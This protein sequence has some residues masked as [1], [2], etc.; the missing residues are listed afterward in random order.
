VLDKEKLDGIIH[1]HFE[2]DSAEVLH[3]WLLAAE[4]QGQDA[5]VS[6]VMSD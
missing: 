4:C 6:S 3:K 2:R 5:K 1:F